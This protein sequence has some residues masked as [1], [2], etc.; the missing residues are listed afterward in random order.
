MENDNFE[1][2]ISETAAIV[3]T[4]PIPSHVRSFESGER[5]GDD[6]SVAYFE[7]DRQCFGLR[8]R[9]T[10]EL[11]MNQFHFHI[12]PT[13]KVDGESEVEGLFVT[14]HVNLEPAVMQ[15]ILKTGLVW[16]IGL[17]SSKETLAQLE[18]G[19]RSSSDAKKLPPT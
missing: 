6:L 14:A 3:R 2:A 12:K 1:K 18:T 15:F 7:S 17:K 8:V 10:S 5:I 19:I 9:E 16:I 13:W 11:N 4:I